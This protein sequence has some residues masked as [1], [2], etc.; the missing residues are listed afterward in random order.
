MISDYL[1]QAVVWKRVTGQNEFG[2]PT[3]TAQAIRVRWEGKRKL[4]R[5]RQGKEIVSEARFFCLPLDA[6]LPGD[7]I[8]HSGKDWPIITV[9]EIVDL[10]GTIIYRKGDC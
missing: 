3:T 2:E 5:D 10:E 1:N 4:V 9:S 7:L 6:V 8:E